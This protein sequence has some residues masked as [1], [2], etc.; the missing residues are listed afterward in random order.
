MSG[1]CKRF[2]VKE[3]EIAG[4]IAIVG[5]TDFVTEPA[6]EIDADE[7]LRDPRFSLYCFDPAND[8]VL[9]VEVK[10]VEA[11]ERAPFYYQGQREQACHLASMPFSMFVA[12]AK[13]IPPPPKSLIFVHSVGRC[14]S[15]L[16][17][18]V[19]E[20]VPSVHSLSEPD[21]L[22]QLARTCLKGEWPEAMMQDAL[23]ASVAW[24]C[25]PRPGVPFAHVAIKPRA[26]VLTMADLLGRA[27]PT[28]RHFFLYRDGLAWMRTIFRGVP[29]ER[30][31]Y[32]EEINRRWE[33]GWADTL[34]LVAEF[35]DEDHPKNIV[36]IRILGWASAMEAYLKLA[37]MPIPTCAARFEDLTER[38]EPILRQILDFCLIEDVD[39]DAIRDVLGRDS[40][41]GTVYDREAR[42]KL[43]REMTEELVQ[44]LYTMLASRPL[45][46][47][48]DVRLPNT[49]SA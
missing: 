15:T 25:K 39:W 43:N 28:A 47:R 20:S 49:I 7:I 44:D 31:V 42:S 35:L 32:D 17:S 41:A 19:L 24:R 36:Q 34:P 11:V 5:P 38:P 30:N 4:P 6:G 48:P 37:A 23:A 9:F 18:K 22:T 21:D 29:P 40:Q 45:L 2:E 12:M 27:F 10:D 46:G 16:V 1:G 33:R 3:L 8:S 26:E 13:T 14:G